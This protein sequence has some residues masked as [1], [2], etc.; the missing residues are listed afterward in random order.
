MRNYGTKTDIELR[1][2]ALSVRIE[3]HPG[4]SSRHR[5]PVYEI[6]CFSPRRQEWEF[7]GYRAFR[8][9]TSYARMYSEL[10]DEWTYDGRYIELEDADPD[11][12]E[13]WHYL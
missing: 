7:K 10:L 4:R 1:G 2:P 8:P 3:Y 9:R 5:C 11:H 6:Y 13:P 12:G